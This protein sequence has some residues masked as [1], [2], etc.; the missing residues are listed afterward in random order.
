MAGSELV[1]VVP[2]TSSGRKVRA[3]WAGSERNKSGNKESEE[4]AFCLPR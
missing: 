2:S 3:A 4:S 1:V